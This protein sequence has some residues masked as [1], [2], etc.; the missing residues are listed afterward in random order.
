MQDQT[1]KL[2]D[3][4][5]QD[6]E[7]TLSTFAD[8][9][10]KLKVFSLKDRIWLKKRFSKTEV[11]T[12]FKEQDIISMAEIAHHLLVDRTEFPEFLDFADKI[13]T[14]QDQI[15]LQKALL[16]TIGIDDEIILNL[17]KKMDGESPNENADSP[18][19]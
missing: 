17:S 2:E 18:K 9:R 6:A 15:N 4:K 14:I 16:K 5:P 8:K 11:E 7:F 12:I 3:L 10:F 1:L 13:I 19:A